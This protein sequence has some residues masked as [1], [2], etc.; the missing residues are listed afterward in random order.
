MFQ[1]ATF[2][3]IVALAG[4]AVISTRNSKTR[5][6]VSLDGVQF[7]YAY[8]NMEDSETHA[9]LTLTANNGRQN[10]SNSSQRGGRS[11]QRGNLQ[12]RKPRPSRQTGAGSSKRGGPGGNFQNRKPGPSLKARG[13]SPRPPRVSNPR[14]G[15]STLKFNPTR[16]R[17]LKTT[18]TRGS[19]LRVRPTKGNN[20]K[21][22]PTKGNNLK[23]R[24]T[25]GNSL[26][27]N[28]VK[29]HPVKI[30]PT[31]GGTLKPAVKP[32][33]QPIRV[34]KP[35]RP[36]IRVV[37]PVVK[38]IHPPIRVIKPIH[39]VKVICPPPICSPIC[40]PG[41]G[42]YPCPPVEIYLPG[43]R[44]IVENVTVEQP[45]LREGDIVS[46]GGQNLGAEVGELQLKVGSIKLFPK[47]LD[48]QDAQFTM[49]VPY[50][51]LQGPVP[52]EL[53]V[54]DAHGQKQFAM[55]VEIWPGKK[56]SL[57]EPEFTDEEL[58]S[59]LTTFNEGDSVPV[60][61]GPLGTESGKVELFLE[62][63]TLEAEVQEW[64]NEYCLVTI[65][66]LGL[67]Q[68]IPAQLT[69]F[70]V[71]GGSLVTLDITIEPGVNPARTVQPVVDDRT[72]PLFQT[73]GKTTQSFDA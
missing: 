68:A 56:E 55:D 67:E 69:V 57:P 63:V 38:P 27:V 39:P 36:P 7:A 47:I 64:S 61:G 71:A 42:W 17:S 16:G 14:S 15:G 48:W 8:L 72:D 24:P 33:G 51:Q 30:N 9:E 28:P 37:K 4:G 20:L 18:P 40:P 6:T 32:I 44:P 23:M 10:R 11:S 66:Y 45:V 22:R 26:K 59:D 53:Q 5:D 34:V 54:L 50:M 13:G 12:N 60:A 49:I 19:T 73:T 1:K 3:L 43:C 70:G 65:P 2:L 29:G 52:A 41:G 46:L 58:S 21:M 25:K 35:I 31:K 62:G